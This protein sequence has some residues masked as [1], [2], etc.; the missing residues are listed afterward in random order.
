M[1]KVRAAL[2]YKYMKLLYFLNI[3]GRVLFQAVTSLPK[4]GRSH[5]I[6]KVLILIPLTLFLSGMP[7]Q[8]SF[9]DSSRKELQNQVTQEFQ[10]NNFRGVIDLY[11]KFTQENPDRSIPLVVRVFYS[12]ALAE[13]GGI[14]K[15]IESLQAILQE[16]PREVD[17][18]KLH[19]DLANLLFM[20]RRYE[21]AKVV[22][23][24]V[25][26]KV[27]DNE[28]I[29]G[30]ARQ[31][32]ALMK[33]REGKKKDVESLKLID[34]E[35]ALEASEVPEGSEFILKAI[36]TR[37]PEGPHAVRAKTLLDRIRELRTEKAKALLDEAR[38]LFDRERKFAEVRNILEQLERDYPDVAD[39]ES[40]RL[41]M[42]EV[43]RRS[44]R[45][46][47]P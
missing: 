23:Q 6:S 31:R 41:L 3:W 44:P 13:T 5:P 38:R 25:L 35:T 39:L 27:R 42:K 10:R 20:E 30:K 15:A 16:M 43:D 32:L 2:N 46:S 21:E 1:P 12:R 37:E 9:A 11:E 18:V 4:M 24:K 28:E 14:E 8:A 17:I 36:L 40:A 29:L 47:I 22:Y 19:Y 45:S 33:D 34:I 7:V 26:L